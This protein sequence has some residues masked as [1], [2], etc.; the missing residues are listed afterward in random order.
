MLL[1]VLRFLR[2]Y[3]CFTV[4]GRFPERFI[5]ISLRNGIRLWGVEGRGDVLSASMYCRDYL[6]IRRYARAS[7]VRLRITRRKGLPTMLRRYSDRAGLVIGAVA[8]VLTIFVMSLFIWTIDIVGL[9]TVSESEMRAMLRENGMYIGAF[10]PSVDYES[11][12]RAIL[13]NDSRVGWMAINV[14]GSYAS[15]ELKEE[16]PSPEVVDTAPCNVKASR[17]GRLLRVEA[18]NGTIVQVEGSGIVDGQ[19]I[20][21]GVMEDRQGGVRLVHAEGSVIAE[22]DYHTELAIPDITAIYTPTGESK[23]RLYADLFGV[24]IPLTVGGV[25]TPEYLCDEG[26]EVPAPLNV[27]LPAGL[28][29]QTLFGMES[30]EV[31]LDNNSAKELLET[32]AHLYEVFT[33][34]NCT[35]TDRRFQV[36]HHADGYHLSADY[37]CT[38]DIAVQEPISTE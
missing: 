28:V 7:G 37:T 3:V 15:V 34:S 33:L 2:G 19:L 20:I 8:F 27:R 24:R 35:V 30:E 14:T 18:K 25:S 32:E 22:T 16:T 36:T 13:L 11:V 29:T 21:S 31:K 5:N 10:K 1:T 38:E 17:D 4:S 6:H 23:R 9:D 26:E 12:S